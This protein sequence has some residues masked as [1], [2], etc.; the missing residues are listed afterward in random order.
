MTEII[1]AIFCGAIAIGC[2]IISVLQFCEK[3]FLFNNAYI[4]AS[5]KER[6]TMDKKPHYRQSGVAFAFIAA[7]FLCMALECLLQTGWL[8][9]LTITLSLGVLVYAVVSSMA[10]NKS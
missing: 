9:W 2:A 1:C 4:W 3:G 5:P 6:E 10:A 8:W 7:I